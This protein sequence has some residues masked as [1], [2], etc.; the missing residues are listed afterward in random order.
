MTGPAQ[1]YTVDAWGGIH[2]FGG[3]GAASTTGWWPG[4]DM[5]RGVGH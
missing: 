4:L 3:A 1:G 5:A 2:P